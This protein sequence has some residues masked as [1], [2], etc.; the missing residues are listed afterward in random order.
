[1]SIFSEYKYLIRKSPAVRT[2]TAIAFILLAAFLLKVFSTNVIRKPVI[3]SVDPQIGYPGDEMTIRGSGFGTSKDSSYVEIA[4]SRVTSSAYKVWRDDEIR[5]VLPS[6]VQDGLV[7]VGTSSG[8]SDP[9]FFANEAGIPVAVRMDP[10]TSIPSIVSVSVESAVI[11]QTITLNGS[12]FGNARGSSEV[13]FSAAADESHSPA[14][15]DQNGEKNDAWIAASE[16]NFDYVAWSDSEIQV[17][18]PDGATTGSV[19][20]QTERGSSG[21]KKLGISFP[22]GKKQYANK[23]TYVIQTCADISN[24]VATQESTILLYIPKPQIS[25][26]QPS[27]ELNEVFPDPFIVDDMYNIIHKKQLNEIVNNKQRF[28]QTYVVSSYCIRSSVNPKGITYY[29][30]RNS[31]VFQRFTT[32]DM[33]VQSDSQLVK[34]FLESIDTTEK[35]PY[36]FARSVYDYFIANFKINEKIRSGD[37]VFTD[38]I[39]RKKG[40]AYDFAILYAAVLRAK[41]IPCI[42]CGGILVHNKSTVTP[43]WW[44]EIYFEN[45]GW[46]PVDPA[47][48]AGLEFE[49]FITIDN[50]TEFYFGNLDNQ[51]VAFSRG[52]RQ[53][54]QSQENSRIVYR[55][56]TYA[57]Q[58]IWEESGDATSSYSSLWNNPIIQGIY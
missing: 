30:N 46:L 56:R 15:S 32:P 16:T 44:V 19:Y 8:R 10:G 29:K 18:V 45:Y 28:S 43:H 48:G 5:L 35:N 49:P 2:V 55:P 20:I 25:S 41:G 26:F 17:R 34:D 9:A 3:A 42:P 14:A 37:A 47:L 54:K 52:F 27:A 12:H 22:A 24:H 4:G 40:D 39:R 51:H 33:C 23:R 31:P 21:S 36:L 38:L 13:Y 6:N 1:M 7:I 11:G 58:S 50:R 53:I 57:L